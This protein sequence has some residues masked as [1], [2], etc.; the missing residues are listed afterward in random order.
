MNNIIQFQ[1]QSI[2]QNLLHAK[3]QT[4]EVKQLADMEAKFCEECKKAINAY[5]EW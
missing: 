2:R 1:N 4:F 3:L 5:R